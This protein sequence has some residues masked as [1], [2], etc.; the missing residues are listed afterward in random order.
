MAEMEQWKLCSIREP[1]QHRDSALWQQIWS[2]AGSSIINPATHIN[3]IKRSR[4][5]SGYGKSRDL[6]ERNIVSVAEKELVPVLGKPL[7]EEVVVEVSLA[8]GC[9]PLFTFPRHT[10]PPSLHHQ[11]WAF[12]LRKAKPMLSSQANATSCFRSTKKESDGKSRDQS[13][14][15]CMG[16]KTVWAPSCLS[17]CRLSCAINPSCCA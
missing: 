10:S 3:F 2:W 14:M 5:G 4:A 6:P 13:L 15:I 11:A 17:C 8:R 16:I 9:S 12:L 7:T 1:R